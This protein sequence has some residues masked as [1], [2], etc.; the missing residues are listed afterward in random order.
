MPFTERQTALRSPA[1]PSLGAAPLGILTSGEVDACFGG[2]V[3]DYIVRIGGDGDLEQ[4]MKLWRALNDAQRDFRIYPMA[5]DA[6]QAAAT[7]LAAALRD[8]D[9]CV[10]VAEER[11]NLIAMA[12]VRV[13]DRTGLNSARVAELSRVVVDPGCRRS[14]IGARLIERAQEW[15]REQGAEFLSAW[16][17]SGNVEG[18][19]FWDRMGFEPRAEERVRPILP[20]GIREER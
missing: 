10:F 4:M 12:A 5:A 9:G 20:K 16:V 15:A 1:T 3:S 6:E 17:F 11:G 13:E 7:M 14:G 19:K 18:K 2:L 8:A